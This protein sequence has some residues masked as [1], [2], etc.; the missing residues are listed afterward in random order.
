MALFTWIQHF[1]T[2]NL[3]APLCITFCQMF[4][5]RRTPSARPSLLMFR[6]DR[7]IAR[8]ISSLVLCRVPR[9]FFFFFC[10]EIVI[11]WTHIGWVGLMFQNLTLPAV[12]QIR[13][14]SSCVI[15]CIVVKNDGFCTSSVVVFSRMLDEGGA[16]GTCIV[17]C[18]PWR[19]SVVQLPHQCHT[20]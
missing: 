1:C 7:P 11:S 12:Q 8:I 10:E 18:L 5:R 2:F 4:R 15:P 19:Y 9:S 3:V 13:D 14:S 6:M 17:Y 20:P 16:V